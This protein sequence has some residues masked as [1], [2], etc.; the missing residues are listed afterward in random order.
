M[1]F[2]KSGRK[3]IIQS[4]RYI[5]SR[6]AQLK[7]DWEASQGPRPASWNLNKDYGQFRPQGCFAGLISWRLKIFF[8]EFPFW[9]SGFSGLRTQ[10]SVPEDACSIPGLFQWA[11]DL[12]LPQAEA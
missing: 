10:H 1:L 5:S 12:V 6:R 11:K 3:Q 4:N 2:L 9:L 7:K 8:Q